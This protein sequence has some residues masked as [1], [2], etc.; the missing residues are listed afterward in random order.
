MNQDPIITATHAAKQHG[1]DG[2][3]VRVYAW[4]MPIPVLWRVGEVA[5]E[6]PMRLAGGPWIA[7]QSVWDE[8]IQSR[9][10]G[11]Q[12]RPGRPPSKKKEATGDGAN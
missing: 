11:R 3:T 7:P 6:W 8:L 1:L 9:E 12:K 10:A 5:Y 2:H 4:S